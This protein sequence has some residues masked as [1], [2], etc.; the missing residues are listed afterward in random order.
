MTRVPPSRYRHSP[1]P[2]SERSKIGLR[3]LL[4]IL[5]PKA[6]GAE[7]RV[8]VGHRQHHPVGVLRL[9]GKVVGHQRLDHLH[10]NALG[11]EAAKLLHQC[12]WK[13]RFLTRGA[14]PAPKPGPENCQTAVPTAPWW[15]ERTGGSASGSPCPA[16]P[17]QSPFQWR[18]T[19]SGRC[20]IPVSGFSRTK[21]TTRCTWR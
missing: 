19:S 11:R 17:G 1:K 6:G 8:K 20:W 18:H 10:R 4:E 12:G 9:V 14:A 13:F 16:R 3:D 2:V 5:P 7:V 21:S 15:W